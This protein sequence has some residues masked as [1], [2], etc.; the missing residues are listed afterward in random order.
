[1]RML[2]TYFTVLRFLHAFVLNLPFKIYCSIY[3]SLVVCEKCV[4]FSFFRAKICLSCNGP[5][6]ISPASSSKLTRIKIKKFIP[7][8]FLASKNNTFPKNISNLHSLSSS[9][10]VLKIQSFWKNLINLPTKLLWHFSFSP[11]FPE[12]STWRFV[13]SNLLFIIHFL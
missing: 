9:H 11:W 7:H 2:Q 6:I 1:M 10:T 8:I 3:N 12:D 5:V 13:P 4:T